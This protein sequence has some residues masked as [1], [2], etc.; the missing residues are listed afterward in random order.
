[1][2]KYVKGVMLFASGIAV[3]TIGGGAYIGLKMLESDGLREALGKEL[4][5][6]I[7]KWVYGEEPELVK[8]NK[9]V[10]YYHTYKTYGNGVDTVIFESRA[11]A[12]EVLNNLKKIVNEFGYCTAADLYEI[13][14]LPTDYMISDLGWKTVKDVTVVRIRDG[15]ILSLPRPTR[16]D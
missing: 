1:M 14:G 10:D 4:G 3:G 2:N 6:K 12:E 13:S 16:I 8:T 15:Y 7:V 9:R 5:N 11:K